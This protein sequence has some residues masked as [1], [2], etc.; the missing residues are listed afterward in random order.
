MAASKAG[1]Y[2]DLYTLCRLLH[3]KGAWQ[4]FT[5]TEK[6]SQLMYI[7]RKG[8]CLSKVVASLRAGACRQSA[9]SKRLAGGWR[10]FSKSPGDNRPGQS[11]R[12][13]R[14]TAPI[15]SLAASRSRGASERLPLPRSPSLQGDD[16]VHQRAA[17]PPRRSNHA[18]A[19]HR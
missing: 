7:A 6:T 18:A 9:I 1:N 8:A 19:A 14:Y 3:S 10:P 16:G 13:I 17:E 5:V 11:I 15:V 2:H 12:I 4:C